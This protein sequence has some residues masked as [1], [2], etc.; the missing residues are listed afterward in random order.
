MKSTDLMSPSL[1]KFFLGNETVIKEIRM[2]IMMIL[3]CMCVHMRLSLSSL[4]KLIFVTLSRST[5][6]ALSFLE[7]AEED[8]FGHALRSILETWPARWTLC[9][10]GWLS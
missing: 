6:I 3:V 1:K 9:W 4:K 10:A 5:T 7:L 8:S 2:A